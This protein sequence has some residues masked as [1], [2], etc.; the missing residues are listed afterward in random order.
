MQRLLP[1]QQRVDAAERQLLLM[2][3]LAAQNEAIQK[4]METRWAGLQSADPAP[5]FSQATL[6][7]IK[8]VTVRY[9]QGRWRYAIYTTDTDGTM[10]NVQL[11]SGFTFTISTTAPGWLG[12]DYPPG[13]RLY[14]GDAN[15]HVILVRASNLNV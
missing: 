10:I 5:L 2:E 4:L 8:E 11:F 7:P 15:R 1:T 3:R 9:E 6:D 12:L 14:S 13:T